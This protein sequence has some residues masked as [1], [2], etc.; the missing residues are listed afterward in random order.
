MPQNSSSRGRGQG[1]QPIGVS[2]VWGC[3]APKW[4]PG[5]ETPIS[6][7][8]PLSSEMVWVCAA[9]PPPGCPSGE[10]WSSGHHAAGRAVPQVK[11]RHLRMP[12]SPGLHWADE[13]L[14]WSIWW[15]GRFFSVC[16]PSR[17]YF[18]I[19]HSPRHQENWNCSEMEKIVNLKWMNIRYTGWLSWNRREAA[20]WADG[21]SA[22]C[23]FFQNRVPL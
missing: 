9:H 23:W 4:D 20:S 14:Q 17:L 15:E 10:G 8:L 16:P 5:S 18:F 6:F 1:Q 21:F 2:P 12:A 7:L 13:R 11:L 3:S 22:A 19:N